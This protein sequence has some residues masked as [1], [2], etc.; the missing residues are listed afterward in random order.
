MRLF[1]ETLNAAQP[2]LYGHLALARGA[3]ESSVVCRWINEPGLA[4]DE[5]VKRGLSEYLY[6]AVEKQRLKLRPDADQQHVDELIAQAKRLGWDVTD[7]NDKPWKPKSRGIPRVDRVARRS[8]PDGITRLLE[9][10][11][12]SK[13]GKKLWSR[14]SA[15]LHA[16]YMGLQSAMLLQ[17]SKPNRLSDRVSV[18]IGT[19]APSVYSHAFIIL[20]AIRHAA[21]ARFELMGWRDADWRK[22]AEDA[23]QLESWLLEAVEPHLAS[24]L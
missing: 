17:E 21:D 4:R 23:K 6:A 11:Q 19:D 24:P 8:V 3:L 22:A 9:V 18:P 16:T 5:R 2:P 15:A 13:I 20:K 14:L 7:A 1:A 10:D 12:N